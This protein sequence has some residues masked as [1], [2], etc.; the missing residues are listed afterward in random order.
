MKHSHDPPEVV[1]IR[2]ADGVEYW[3]YEPKTGYI[4]LDEAYLARVSHGFRN[5]NERAREQARDE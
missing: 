1:R 2:H 4:P 5:L 3:M